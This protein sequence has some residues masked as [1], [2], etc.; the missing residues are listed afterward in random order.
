M[1]ISSKVSELIMILETAE[2]VR[3]VA[4]AVGPAVFFLSSTKDGCTMSVLKRM[5][6]VMVG[7]TGGVLSRPIMIG[8]RREDFASQRMSLVDLTSLNAGIIIGGSNALKTNTVVMAYHTVP[9][10][11]TKEAVLQ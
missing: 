9:T 6:V 11:Q 7:V 4:M 1:E 5:P 2:F 10:N 3:T 8:T